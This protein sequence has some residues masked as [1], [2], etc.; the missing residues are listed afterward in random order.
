M[1]SSLDILYIVIAFGVLWVTLFVCWF[2]YQLVTII[3]E[4]H[5]T[6]H[7]LTFAIENVEKALQGIK[8][9][10]GSG[11]LSEHF[12]NTVSNIKDKMRK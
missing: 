5:S 1:F 6:V 2:I 8:S 7:K 4:I 9:K 11:N 12:K 3:R 10:F